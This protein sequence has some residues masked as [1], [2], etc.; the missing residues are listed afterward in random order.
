MTAEQRA[1]VIEFF[2]WTCAAALILGGFATWA[3]VDK[4]S[5]YPWLE[6][7]TLIES[8][9]SMFFG[10]AALG[11]VLIARRSMFLKTKQSGPRYLW[12]ALW[13]LL[14]FVFMGEEISWGQRIFSTVTPQWLDTINL[15]KETNVHNVD[16]VRNFLGGAHRWLSIL[17]L[18]TGLVLPAF[19]ETGYGKR[20][21]QWWGFPVCPIQFWLFFVGAYAFGV[22]VR[23]YTFRTNDAAEVREFVFSIGMACFALY[24]AYR[25]WSVFRSSERTAF[26]LIK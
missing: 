19:A 11:F 1:E 8:L 10:L 16:F 12:V 21:I 18:L 5:L 3:L 22:I 14:M 2:G 6:E 4:D 17:M 23:E 7:D 25:P 9:T 20:V 15:Q 24:G 26:P 13:A